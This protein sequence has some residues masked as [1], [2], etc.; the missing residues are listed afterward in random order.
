[1]WDVQDTVTPNHQS[2]FIHFYRNRWFWILCSSYRFHGIALSGLVL[3]RWRLSFSASF[4]FGWTSLLLFAPFYVDTASTSVCDPS[5]TLQ[6]MALLTAAERWRL[7]KVETLNYA[8]SP[9]TRLR[10][11]DPAGRHGEKSSMVYRER[12]GARSIHSIKRCYT[13]RTWRSWELRP[14]SALLTYLSRLHAVFST[15]S[16]GLSWGS[17]VPIMSLSFKN[18]FSNS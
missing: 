2:L 12:A 1:M 7:W 5:A 14:L 16:P 18:T 6:A 4:I 3:T 10:G 17:I 15:L 9:S 11:K 8:S 13:Y